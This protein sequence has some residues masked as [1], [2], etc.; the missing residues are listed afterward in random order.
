MRGVYSYTANGGNYLGGKVESIWV[1]T[2]KDEDEDVVG[3]L[4]AA[5]SSEAMRRHGFLSSIPFILEDIYT[6]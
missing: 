6:R 1:H 5:D 4:V 3:D 2:L